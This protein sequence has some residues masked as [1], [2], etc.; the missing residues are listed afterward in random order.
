MTHPFPERSRKLYQESFDSFKTLH[1]E[2]FKGSKKKIKY[3]RAY[4]ISQTKFSYGFNDNLLKGIYAP[5][6]HEALDNSIYVDNCTTVIPRIYLAAECVDLDPQI[7]QFIDFRDVKEGKEHSGYRNSSHFAITVDVGRNYRYLI[8]PFWDKF[9]PIIKIGKHHM[10]LG[11]NG[12]SSAVR[13][14][15]REVLEYTPEEFAAMIERLKDPAE[16]LDMLV[17]GQK[18]YDSHPVNDKNCEVMVYYDDKK[19]VLT[20]R[21]HMFNY[22]ISDKG[23]YCNLIL[24]DNGDVTSYDLRFVLG[25]N[26]YWTKLGKEKTVARTDF[27]GVKKVKK[28]LKDIPK[29]KG[30][31]EGIKSLEEE[32][33]DSLMELVDDLWNDL[34]ESERRAIKP[35]VLSRTLYEDRDSECRFSKSEHDERIKKLYNRQRKLSKRMWK[36]SPAV[37]LHNWK[38]EKMDKKDGK[39][40][41][42]KLEK[43]KKRNSKWINETDTLLRFR[44]IRGKVYHRRMDMILFAK[45]LEGYSIEDMEEMV[46]E[47]DLDYRYGYLAMVSDFIPFALKGRK[48][49]EL[50][51]FMDNIKEKVKARRSRDSS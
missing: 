29:D 32:C 26:A 37:M 7:V 1:P 23:L 25:K 14:E 8:D 17:V 45:E 4:G 42:A 47:K 2:E 21:L 36:F 30:L 39:R 9:N 28:L 40:L 35:Q 44:Y 24:G 51:T 12:K 18:I 50:K 27:S 46:E 13:R 6:P 19:N 31:V 48:D 10:Q 33:Q 22:G 15:F 41:D 34:S 5:W 3:S 16:S 38:I 43:L 20:T 49:L 11:K